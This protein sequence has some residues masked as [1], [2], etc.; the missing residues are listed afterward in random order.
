[1]IF[2][3]IFGLRWLDTAFGLF[4]V[5]WL[6]TAFRYPCNIVQE[7][8]RR[9][10]IVN[11]VKPPQSKPSS[12]RSPKALFSHSVIVIESAQLKSSNPGKSEKPLSVGLHTR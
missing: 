9:L 11:G 10:R 6:D 12:R 8:T 7:S 5:R 4:G 2:I 3:E 1:M